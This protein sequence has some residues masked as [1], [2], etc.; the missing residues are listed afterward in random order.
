VP[1]TGR[2]LVL[3]P[4]ISKSALYAEISRMTCVICSYMFLRRKAFVSVVSTIKVMT[5]SRL[6]YAPRWIT[7]DTLV[8][9]SDSGAIKRM[10]L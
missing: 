1:T 3:R 8:G 10:A 4:V 7:S 6:R 5:G 9:L 2:Y